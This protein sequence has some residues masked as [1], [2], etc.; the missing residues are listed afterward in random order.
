MRV[1]GTI[2]LDLYKQA[3]IFYEVADSHYEEVLAQFGGLTP[4]ITK[5]VF[6]RDER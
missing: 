5:P 6:P 4:G 2:V 1:D 3:R